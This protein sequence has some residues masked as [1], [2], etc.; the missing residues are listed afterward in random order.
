MDKPSF[1]V[2]FH[3]RLRSEGKG[4]LTQVKTVIQSTDR[5]SVKGDLERTYS[6][7]NGLKIHEV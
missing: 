4:N 7:V 6:V 3:G 1:K 5:G 2:K